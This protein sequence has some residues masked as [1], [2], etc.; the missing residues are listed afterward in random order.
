[1]STPVTCLRRREKVGVIVDILS[2]TASNHNGFPVVESTDDTQVPGARQ[3]D[4]SAAVPR[5]PVAS[6]RLPPPQTSQE[7]CRW[8]VHLPSRA[9]WGGVMCRDAETPRL[10]L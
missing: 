6:G 5:E 9:C 4:G 10:G 3:V 2:N 7:S 8:P 1:M